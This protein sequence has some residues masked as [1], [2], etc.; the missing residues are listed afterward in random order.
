MIKIVCVGGE[1][2]LH[3]VNKCL[4]SFVDQTFKDWEMVVVLDPADYKI[5]I[6]DTRIKINYNKKTMLGTA[7]IIQA[8]S[9]HNL[10]DEDIIVF[11]DADDWLINNKSLQVVVDT[12]NQ[13]PETLVTHGSFDTLPTRE[14]KLYFITNSKYTREEFSNL[15]SSIWKGS[16][17]RT[18][19]YRVFKNIKDSDLRDD[20]GVYFT[21]GCDLAVMYPAL[22]MAG[23]DRVKFIK[24]I[25]YVY[26]LSGVRTPH[27]HL[28]E[29]LRHKAILDNR[30]PYTLLG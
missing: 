23:Y 3:V 14:P 28:N 25:I 27:T 13:H 29:S 17:L 4:Q 19:K 22:E 16:A 21:S 6:D 2:C 9:M 7:N 15:R 11:M 5:Y 10:T 12:Y 20:S 24:D 8:I 26:N 18:M 1:P 30:K